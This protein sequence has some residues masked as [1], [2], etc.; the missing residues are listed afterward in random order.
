[1]KQAKRSL[2][3]ICRTG[4]PG[5][6][7]WANAEG[8]RFDMKAGQTAIDFIHECQTHIEGALAGQPFLLEDWQKAIIGNLFGWKRRDGTRRYREAFVFVSRKNG[9]SPLAAC[10]ANYMLF[11]DGEAGAQCYLAAA[12]RDQATVLFR[13]C[14]GMI[15]AEPWLSSKCQIYK[16]AR[17]IV[18]Q[19][20]GS[21][22]KVL[23]AEA[24]TKHGGNSHLVI[25]DELHAQPNRELVDTLQ[26]SF[27]SANR[28]Q[29]L[30]LFI[31][32]A[33]FDRE[34]ICNEKHDYA[35]K[36][37]DGII[38]DPA[39]LPVIY[40]ASI[41]E[42]WCD[43]V[44]WR[45]ANPNLGVSVSQEYL[46]RESK[47][48]QETPSYL[49]T[50]LRLH[51]NV[52]TQNDKAWLN[53]AKWDAGGEMPV[54]AGQLIGRE[55]FAGLDL[56]STTDVAALSLVF[57]DDDGYIVLPFFWIPE[58]NA[59]QRERK[60]RVPYLTWA[61]EG[62]IDL[63]SGNVIDYDVIRTKIREL[64]EIYNIRQIAVDRWNATQLV[65]QLGGD[66]FDVVMFGQGYASMTAPTK[67]LEKL[68]QAGQLSHGGNPV[69]RWMASNVTTEE[70][71]A[72]N[73]KPSKSK[74]TEK[75]DGIVATIMAL[76]VA[77]TDAGVGNYQYTAGSM[78]S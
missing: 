14:K 56:A 70:D 19:D 22:L 38:V 1:M 78:S 51:L 40:E 42:D 12:D 65:T 18:M 17:S 45:K 64:G 47:R 61:R 3:D 25:V 28:K 10:I 33:D 53:M 7:P 41:D 60:D 43:P 6:D 52:K 24:E 48:A 15:E 2:E 20:E 39:F 58:D 29:P 68:N 9:K 21:S 59:R 63:T 77:A 67:E 76:G 27:A 5:Y 44:V 35:G 74:S 36:V 57:P 31:T 49:N 34:S 71:A 46:E 32:T 69:L 62:Y 26:T 23:S 54:D 55:C 66:G 50:F 37:R 8:M 72:G 16:A 4:I 73:L 30:L 75:I 11:C 13:H